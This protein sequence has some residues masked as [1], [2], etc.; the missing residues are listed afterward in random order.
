MLQVASLA[1]FDCGHDVLRAAWL[2]RLDV[3]VKLISDVV[4]VGFKI[5]A[6][7]TIA[8]T[9]LPSLLGTPGGGH[10]FFERVYLLLG[11]LGHMQLVGAGH[12]PDRDRAARCWASACFPEGPVALA[13]VALAIVADDRARAARTRRTGDGS[14]SGRAAHP[15][16]PRRCGCAMSK[17]LC[18]SRSVACLL[19]YIEG[20]SAARAFAAKHGYELDPRQEFLGLG[21]ANLFAAALGKAIPVAG[22]LSQSAVNDKAGATHPARACLCLNHARVVPPVPD[23]PPG[24][25]AQGGACGR[26]AHRDP[27]AC[28]IFAASCACG[29]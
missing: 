7:L 8:M 14:H 27:R 29:A 10:N 3:L 15:G 28:S 9:Q 12:W 21:A 20:V 11:Q 2:L 17:A 16:E 25:P 13:V 24:K 22:G 5:G 1:G 6:G 4:L 26:G 23:R 19:A 18:R